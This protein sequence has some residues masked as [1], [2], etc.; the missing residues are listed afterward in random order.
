MLTVEKIG[1]TSMS[2]LD[3]V[4][5]NIILHERTGRDLYNRIFVVSAF[6]GVTNLLLE[7]K[8]TGAPGVYRKVATNKGFQSALTDLKVKLKEL[9]KKYA[10]LGL[11]VAEADAFIEN[12]VNQAQ[13]YLES[14]T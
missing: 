14:L 2:A 11:N 4:L 13:K 1:G 8:K 10:P 5:Q 3:D 6:A 9:N 12:R 7:N